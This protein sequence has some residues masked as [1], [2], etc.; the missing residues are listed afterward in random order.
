M[1]AVITMRLERPT[2]NGTL[3]LFETIVA[4]KAEIIDKCNEFI[5]ERQHREGFIR[6]IEFVTVI[7]NTK[8]QKIYKW[9][10]KPSYD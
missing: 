5:Y 7:Y 3:F 8:K 10:Y 4:K 9:K 1:K 2:R 6:V